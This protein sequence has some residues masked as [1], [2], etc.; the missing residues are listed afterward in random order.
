[1]F[2]NPKALGSFTPDRLFG[3][4]VHETL[5]SYMRIGDTD[6]L[7]KLGLPASGP[8]ARISKRIASS[9]R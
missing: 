6:L 5:H 9:C 2:V 7:T 1:M 3:L 4:V 8:S